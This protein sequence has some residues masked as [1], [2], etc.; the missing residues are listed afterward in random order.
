MLNMEI[1]ASRPV[2]LGFLF[3][4][5]CKLGSVSARIC[6]QL[7]TCSCRIYDEGDKDNGKIISLQAIDPG[8]GPR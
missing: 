4:V 3:T 2:Y 6:L 5:L 1:T 8:N 7:D